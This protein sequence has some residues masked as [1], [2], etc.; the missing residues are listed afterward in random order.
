MALVC[1]SYLD[2]SE[3]SVDFGMPM[4]GI[5]YYPSYDRLVGLS[6]SYGLPEMAEVNNILMV[7]DYKL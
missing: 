1:W 3:T 7:H 2:D 6:C 5:K 4:E